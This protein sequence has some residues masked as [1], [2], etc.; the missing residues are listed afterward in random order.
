MWTKVDLLLLLQEQ[1]AHAVPC[2]GLTV[3]A[4]RENTQTPPPNESSQR[5]GATLH[6]TGD[7]SASPT[8]QPG[9]PDTLTILVPPKTKEHSEQQQ[10]LPSP[11]PSEDEKAPFPEP[12]KANTLPRSS[13]TRT[14][15]VLPNSIFDTRKPFY[16]DAPPTKKPRPNL[17][18]TLK[19]RDKHTP[20][21]GTSTFRTSSSRVL[22]PSG[23]PYKASPGSPSTPMGGIISRYGRTPATSSTVRPSG[24]RSVVA[25]RA[26]RLSVDRLRSVMGHPSVVK[27]TQKKSTPEIQRAVS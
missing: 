21:S 27:K 25:R 19:L 20:G 18:Q 11:L 13:G 23:T 4:G 8:P 2:S 6:V 22:Y 5:T 16:A 17:N 3:G 10:Q 15:T 12:S 26:D 9:C 7:D 24:S 1:L 14:S